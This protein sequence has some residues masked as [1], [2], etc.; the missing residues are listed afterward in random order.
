MERRHLEAF[1]CVAKTLSFSKAAEKMYISQPTVS[2]YINTLEKSLGAQLFVRNTKEVALTK[3]GRDFLSYAQKILSLQEQALQCVSGKDWNLHGEIDI[4]AS[5][6]PA[7]HLL[8]EIIA[9]FCK[10]WPDVLFRVDQADSRRVEREMIGFRYDFGMVGAMPDDDRFIHYPVYDDEL[11]LAVPGDAEESTEMIRENFVEYITRVPFIMRES[12]SGTRAEIE[13]LLSRIGVG[14]RELRISA[15][16]PDTHSIIL[17]VSRGMGISLISKVAAAMY[18][19]TGELR[20][21]EMNSPL[22]HRQI[23][24][25]YGKNIWLSPLQQAFADHARQFFYK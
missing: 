22:F 1:I 7:Q 25:L 12:G 2:A 11:V 4:I 13:A 14:F 15:Y 9:S 3:A 21:V 18:E 23:H 20:T 10:E 19:K 24:L 5:T 16:F 17:A 6:I 8:P